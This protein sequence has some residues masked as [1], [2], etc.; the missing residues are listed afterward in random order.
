MSDI[1]FKMTVATNV[2]LVR[3]NN[4]DNFIVNP[5]LS[6]QD[7]WFVP[8]SPNEPMDM[9]E[10]GCVMVVADG[11]GGMNAGEVAS[12]LAVNGIKDSFSNITDFS[13]II[14]SSNHI[15]AFL[16]KSIVDAD[17]QIKKKV[18]EDASTSG[19]G[20]TIVVAWIIGNVVHVAWCG[21]S[22][23][24]LFNRQAGALSRLSKDHSYVQSLV[25]SGQLD[26]ELAFDHPNSNIITRSLGDSATKAQPDYV[27]KRLSAGDYIL[28]CTDGLC[29]LVRD[30]E[31]LNVLM[32]QYDSIEDYRIALFNAA[33]DAGAYDNVTIALLECGA[34]HEK[35]LTSTL[36]PH[37][38]AKKDRKKRNRKILLALLIILLI[39]IA[40]LVAAICL[41]VIVL[42]DAGHVRIDKN[43]FD[44]FLQNDDIK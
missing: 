42:D 33:F 36:L 28:L 1:T 30:E 21:D 6:K 16:K 24:Y 25:D 9:G 37:E 14:D 38:S 15:E 26:P 31:I 39:C 27:C 8:S 3:T 22:R 32:Q 17:E 23:A 7:N 10:Y 19:M 13:K 41:D 34:M 35:E 5:D 20:T 43:I 44:V 29:G 40:L 2:G 12:E 11:M 4:E 18:K